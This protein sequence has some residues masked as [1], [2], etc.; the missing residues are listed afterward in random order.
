MKTHTER[1]R[2]LPGS[3]GR[4]PAIV[5]GSPTILSVINR[6]SFDIIR[7]VLGEP[8]S[9]AGW[10]PALPNPKKLGQTCRSNDAP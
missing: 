10:Q 3:A 2:L 1:V 4:W 9:T 7:V 8:P 6:S 5:G